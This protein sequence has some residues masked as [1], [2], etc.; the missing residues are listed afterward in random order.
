MQNI[1]PNFLIVG[2]VKAGTTSLASA[3]TQHP[4]VYIPA[5]KEVRFFSEH[6]WHKGLTWYS[7]IFSEANGYGAIGEASPAYTQFPTDTGVPKRIHEALGDIKYI[8]L[9]RH[10]IDRLVSHYRHALYHRWLP[11]GV[12][13]EEA[14]EIIPALK[15]CSKYHFQLKQYF[16][17]TSPEQWLLVVL[18][19]LA[20]NPDNLYDEIFTFL[21]VDPSF[22]VVAK[23]ENVTDKKF[24]LPYWM[25]ILDSYIFRKPTKLRSTVKKLAM[26]CSGK[27]IENPVVTE[28]LWTSLLSELSHDIEKLSSF[29]GKDF[30]RIWHID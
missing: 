24:Q 9:V 25:V 11:N 29:T 13:L 14:V 6:N 3:L 18:E 19:E 4:D 5:M 16:P 12:T 17:Y 30:K 22:K 7:N 23:I 15:N 27:Q 8:Y 21:G 10:P 20:Q 28:A 1:L 26:S 2:A